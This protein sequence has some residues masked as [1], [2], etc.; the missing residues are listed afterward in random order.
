MPALRL[1]AFRIAAVAP[2]IVPCTPERTWIDGFAAL[3]PNPCPPVALANTHGWELLVPAAFEVAW[4][5]G[6]SA[7]DLVVRGIEPFPDDFPIG[8]FAAS[9]LGQG[10]V[11]LHTGYLFRTPPDWSL[12]VT[13]A[14]NEPRKGIAALTGVIETGQ[15]QDPLIM[16]WLMLAPGTARF[17]KDEV[18]CTV[19]PIRR[20]DLEEWEF[21]IHDLGDDPSLAMRRD[22]VRDVWTAPGA[23]EGDAARQKMAPERRYRFFGAGLPEGAKTPHRDGGLRLN[24]PVDRSGTRP[25]L[26]PEPAPSRTPASAAPG[27]PPTGGAPPM[28]AVAH[29]WP[30][31]MMNTLDHEQNDL[32]RLGR[33]RLREGVLTPSPTTAVIAPDPDL[34][35]R[36]FDFIY[37]PGFLTPGECALLTETAEALAGM[38]QSDGV[39]DAFWK[40]RFLQ[41]GDVLL[42][43]PGAAALMRD[44]QGRVTQRLRLFYELTAPIFADTVALVRWRPGMFMDPHADRA[45]PDGGYHGFPH[46]DFGSIVYI[47]DEYAG[48]ELYFPRL[49]LV[50]KP[51]LGLLVAFT[52][53]W[54]HEHA[55][56]KVRSGDRL[57]M[58]AFY[59]FDAS[60][61]ERDVYGLGP[62]AD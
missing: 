22:R 62:L 44:A 38:Q 2:D 26:T 17:E 14:F 7:S 43:R 55:V 46:R 31:S 50:V 8:Q 33:R 48:G 40:G 36:A 20:N 34:D 51:T 1:E 29:W 59:T 42:R 18:V 39:E 57:T 24:P 13:G 25:V 56:I 47:N 27:G 28:P 61:R 11:S 21:A 15:R 52:G 12:L 5:G 35:P 58:S 32:N 30:D 10:I 54:H 60:H 49:D 37:Q 4:N 19:L 23:R 6:P 45:N 41:F 3:G 16:H 53:G 9:H